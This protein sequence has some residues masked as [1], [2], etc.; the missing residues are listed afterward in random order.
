MTD[1]PPSGQDIVLITGTA[2]GTF[3]TVNGYPAPE[4][5][6]VRLNYGGTDYYYRLTYAGSVK[7]QWVS[8]L[9]AVSFSVNGPTDPH[10]DGVSMLGAPMFMWPWVPPPT[11]VGAGPF[12]PIRLPAVPQAVGIFTFRPGDV[13]DYL[14]WGEV[15]EAEIFQSEPDTSAGGVSNTPN[16][17]NNQILKTVAMGLFPTPVWYKHNI[18][19]YTFGE[20]FFN[21]DEDPQGGIPVYPEEWPYR[22]TAPGFTEPTVAGGGLP[23]KLYFSVDPWAIGLSGTNV[24]KEATLNGTLALPVGPIGTADVDTNP[25]PPPNPPYG[26]GPWQSN[27]EAAGDVFIAEP[28][29]LPS[30]NTIVYDD[31]VLALH[32]PYDTYSMMEDDLDAL[33]CVG[34]NTLAG[35]IPAEPG[36]T[37]DRVAPTSGVNG[38]VHPP[39]LGD[40]PNP[41]HDPINGNPIIF[42]IDR[43]SYG[44]PGSAVATQVFNPNEG[45]AADLFIAVTIQTPFGLVTTN[46]LLVDEGQLGL[47]PHDDLDAVIVRLLIPTEELERR[48]NEAAQYYDPYNPEGSQG[49]GFT[50][51]LLGPGEAVVGFSVDTSSIGLMFSC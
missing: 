42:S 45:A 30:K 44:A 33:E 22:S 29:T 38:G 20:D 11:P 34:T 9:G 28:V 41:N 19:A 25:P 2:T 39:D 49:P 36:N 40:P 5:A 4:G 32:G 6:L 23:I 43:G 18:N 7:L 10:Y 46:M 3:D 16:G 51:P 1:A 37:H 24:R 26:T 14:L 17:T 48:I 13:N 50:I 8:E 47:M 35:G 15:S 21:G 31:L 12:P 27:G